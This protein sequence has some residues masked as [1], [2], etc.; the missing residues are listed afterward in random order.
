TALLGVGG[1]AAGV[2]HAAQAGDSTQIGRVLVA[3]LAQAPAVWVLAGVTVA[4]YGISRQGVAVAWSLLVAF[5]LLGEFGALFDL[6]RAVQDLSP[7]THMP[8]LPGGEI[9]ATPL[10]VCTGVAAV[11]VVAG[12]AALHRRDIV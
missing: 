4:A 6:P 9:V 3:A 12:L 1:L 5:L 2:A 10:L 11:L 7:F 8:K